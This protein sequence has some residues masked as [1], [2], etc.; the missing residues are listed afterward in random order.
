MPKHRPSRTLWGLIGCHDLRSGPCSPVHAFFFLFTS[1]SLVSFL[2]CSPAWCRGSAPSRS[3]PHGHE[4]QTQRKAPSRATRG[5]LSSPWRTLPPRE[6]GSERRPLSRTRKMQLF[7]RLGRNACLSTC[8]G[9]H[10]VHGA[11]ADT[12]FTYKQALGQGQRRQVLT[13]PAG[14]E[15]PKASG[16]RRCRRWGGGC[17]KPWAF[18]PHPGALGRAGARRTRP[19]EEPESALWPPSNRK[20]TTKVIRLHRTH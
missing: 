5:R 14:E 8:S 2:A 6:S 4:T 1:V 15:A 16:R 19:G 11:C 3:R 12:H 18:A 20:S 9:A 7:L 13:P 17:R 10:S